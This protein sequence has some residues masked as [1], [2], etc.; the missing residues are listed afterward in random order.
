MRDFYFIPSHAT[1]TEGRLGIATVQAK[2]EG[3]EAEEQKETKRLPPSTP[4][5]SK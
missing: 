2:R 3:E 1:T 4:S 5:H